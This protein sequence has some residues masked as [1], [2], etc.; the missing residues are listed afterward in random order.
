MGLK[1]GRRLFSRRKTAG[2][3]TQA[4]TPEYLTIVA[5][6]A[7]LSVVQAFFGMGVLIFGTPT[8]LLLGYDFL[9]TLSYLL[10]ASFAISLLQVLTAGANRVP[11]SRYLYL[12]C[13]PG[14]GAGLWF[15]GSSPLA[16]RKSVV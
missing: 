4:M 10:P 16:D 8:L 6:I 11:V 5:V 3:A 15:A 12:L 7:L 9:T 13:L 2:K 14:I 1:F